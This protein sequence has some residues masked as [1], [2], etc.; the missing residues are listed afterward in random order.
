MGYRLVGFRASVDDG[1]ERCKNAGAEI[2]QNC[3]HNDPKDR[4]GIECRGQD[5]GSNTIDWV[6]GNGED[7]S[8]TN[9]VSAW[10]QS[11]QRRQPT[12]AFALEKA[13]SYMKIF[14]AT[15]E[16]LR[17]ELDAR[18]G[19]K[20]ED[21]FQLVSKKHTAR[22]SGNT[23]ASNRRG[24]TRNKKN[25][26]GTELKDFY[27]FQLRENK[28]NKLSEL[29]ERFNEDKERVEHLR[30]NKKFKIAARTE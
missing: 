20:D 2:S 27:R 21:G 28:R 11:F 19:T 23:R 1:F 24:R 6:V 13:D 7:G 17:D 5:G 12:M 22:S 4:S 30:S 10:V 26:A 18:R 9:Q 29:R 15:K 25:G 8:A 16:T 14:V 3:A